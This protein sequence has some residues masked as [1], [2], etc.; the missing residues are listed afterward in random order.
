[1]SCSKL[2]YAC[3]CVV[4]TGEEVGNSIGF[5]EQQENGKQR[6]E[7]RRFAFVS[8]VDKSDPLNGE[9]NLD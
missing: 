1:M 3:R 5:K 4:R 2:W 9:S 6:G 8:G 7:E